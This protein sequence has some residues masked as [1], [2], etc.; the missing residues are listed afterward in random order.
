[1]QHYTSD[2]T[3]KH[4]F[5]LLWMKTWKVKEMSLLERE[6]ERE[7]ERVC[8]CVCVCV[9]VTYRC[10]GLLSRRGST[11]YNELCQSTGTFS[12]SWPGWP[13]LKRLRDPWRLLLDCFSSCYTC[14]CCCWL[15]DTRWPTPYSGSLLSLTAS[16]YSVAKFLLT[17]RCQ[18]R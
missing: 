3:R 12:A 13:F 7:R 16:F 18:I 2:I 10:P 15:V 6:R 14:Y 1:M 4:Y 8:M 11:G 17:H 5:L 9:C